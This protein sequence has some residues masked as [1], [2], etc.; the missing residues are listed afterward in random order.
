MLYSCEVLIYFNR[1]FIVVLMYV[2]FYVHTA[3]VAIKLQLGNV[4]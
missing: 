2:L 4:K 1:P 3:Q